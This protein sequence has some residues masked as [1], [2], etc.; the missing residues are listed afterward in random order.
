LL[1]A[2]TLDQFDPLTSASEKSDRL[3]WVACGLLHS[4]NSRYCLDLLRVQLMD[5]TH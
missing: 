4:A 5:A 3:R 2:A 1:L